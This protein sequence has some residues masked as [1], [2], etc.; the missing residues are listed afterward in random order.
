MC[1][2][3]KDFFKEKDNKWWPTPANSA[4]FDPIERIWAEMKHYKARRVKPFSKKELVAGITSF[5]K[6]RMTAEICCTYYIGYV[7]GHNR[8][9]NLYGN[10][11]LR[12]RM[13]KIRAELLNN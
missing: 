7:A 12:K 8:I 10:S 1:H 11:V 5:W 2:V 6:D 4:D 13:R 9:R 3:A